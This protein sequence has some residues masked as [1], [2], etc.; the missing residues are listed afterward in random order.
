MR[1]LNKKYKKVSLRDKVHSELEK[2]YLAKYGLRSKKELG[3]GRY[4]IEKA[5][6]IYALKDKK[7]TDYLNHLESNRKIGFLKSDEDLLDLTLDSYFSRTLCYIVSLKQKIRIK[8]AR[9]KIT[10]GLVFYNGKRN[11]SP[12]TIISLVK[13][14]LITIKK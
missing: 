3:R 7:K 12:R 6:R 8:A 4:Y 11:R 2:N 1:G 9:K 5:Y 13:E 10:S 14:N